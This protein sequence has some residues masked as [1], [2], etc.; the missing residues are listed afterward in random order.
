MTTET[1]TALAPTPNAG[2][3]IEERKS[4]SALVREN[5]A[6]FIAGGV[7]L[8]LV[9]GALIPKRATGSLTKRALA[10]AATAGELGLAASRQARESAGRAAVDARDLAGKA[11]KEAGKIIDRDAV[12]VREKAGQLAEVA[13]GAG[14]KVADRA[15]SLASRLKH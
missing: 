13:R 6:A 1:D 2:D 11:A 8:G 4:L 7:V 15:G 9:L 3:T 14:A 10:L 5:P 12:I